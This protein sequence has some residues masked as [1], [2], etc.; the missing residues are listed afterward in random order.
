MDSKNRVWVF[1]LVLDWI[2]SNDVADLLSEE[3]IAVRSWKHCAH[4]YFEN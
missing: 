1:S 4:S 2:H 3:N